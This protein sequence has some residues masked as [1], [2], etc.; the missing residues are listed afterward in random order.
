MNNIKVIFNLK[1]IL[2]DKGFSYR[3]FAALSGVHF[4]TIAKIANNETTHVDV[5]VLGKL[6]HALGHN[7]LQDVCKIVVVPEQVAGGR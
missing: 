2:Q 7:S 4:T 6:A 5:Q 3:Q 1:Q